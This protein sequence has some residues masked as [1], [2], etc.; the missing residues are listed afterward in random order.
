MKLAV[1]EAKKSKEPI[2][3]GCVIVKDGKVIAGGYNTQRD[4]CDASAH[5]E[6][7]AIRSAG[8]KLKS[9]YLK[10]CTIYTT[11]EPCV[12]CLTA[13]SYARIPWLVYG[14]NL[15]DVVDKNRFLQIGFDELIEKMPNAPQVVKNFMKEETDKIN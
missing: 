9:K 3:V 8:K 1:N 12:M 6:V 7:N 4:D 11:C 5:A 14:S 2:K 13:I 15:G 10:D